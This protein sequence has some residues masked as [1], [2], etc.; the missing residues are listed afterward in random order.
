MLSSKDYE[1]LLLQDFS[2]LSVAKAVPR[3]SEDSSLNIVVI[4]RQT[5]DS[6]PYKKPPLNSIEGLH[7]IKRAIHS[8]CTPFMG[9]T[10]NF[11]VINPCYREIGFKVYIEFK[12]DAVT[13]EDKLLLYNDIVA[14]VNPW[15]VTKKQPVKFGC[16]F[17]Y[18]EF[19]SFIQ[20]RSYVSAL[21]D[22]KM[23]FYDGQELAFPK[24]YEFKEEEVLIISDP[25]LIIIGDP[26]EYKRLGISTM[27]I[28]QDF[29]VADSDQKKKDK[30]KNE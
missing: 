1:D 13:P 10:I 6:Y 16:W 24:H 12:G 20:S 17:E 4:N 21:Y 29:I 18:A 23:G 19:A 8:F 26:E 28:D 11:N 25:D 7:E 5:Y 22:I 30:P 9:N 2:R 15:K 14:F 27:V 3:L